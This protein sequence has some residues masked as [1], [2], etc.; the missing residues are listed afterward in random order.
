VLTCTNQRISTC[1]FTARMAREVSLL[2]VRRVLGEWPQLGKTGRGRTECFRI[3]LPAIQRTRIYPSK[4][5][6][7]LSATGFGAAE[8][9]LTASWR[10]D[11]P[12]AGWRIVACAPSAGNIA[13]SHDKRN[14]ARAS[15]A[16][17]HL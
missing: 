14:I 5:K 15:K 16:N 7:I 13:A 1:G 6:G 11:L 4:Y 17:V 3:V 9:S 2:R 8:R 12:A 10:G